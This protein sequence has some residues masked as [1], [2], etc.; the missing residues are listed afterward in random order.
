[1]AQ[2]QVLIK[3]AILFGS[4]VFGFI[5]YYFVNPKTKK[6]KEQVDFI[7]NYL[8]TYVVFILV[9]KV[10][11]HYKLFF[12]DPMAVLAYPSDSPAFY[13]GTILFIVAIIVQ[14]YLE[15]LQL[16]SL[17]HIFVPVVVGGSFLYE[18]IQMQF[19]DKG[20]LSYLI[21]HILLLVG[22]ILLDRSVRNDLLILFGW[23]VGLVVLSF[24]EPFIM[25]FQF[26]VSIW[27]VLFMMIVI[28]VTYIYLSRRKGI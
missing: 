22:Y 6:L 23:M 27:F 5:V 8:I 19:Y 21:V 26:I 4:F 14:L 18:F 10:L 7:G 17:I 2:I 20:A 9:G 3:I 1:M 24:V 28:V 11:Y 16:P 13:I 15:K 12:K 25:I